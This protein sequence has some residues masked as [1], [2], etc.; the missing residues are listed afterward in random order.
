M[1][2]GKKIDRI[3][4]RPGVSVLSVLSHLNYRPWFALAE[5][6]DNSIQSF[7][8]YRDEIE[9]I[10]NESVIL[11]ITIEIDPSD[12]GR[13]TVR[14][15]AAGIHQT[16]FPRA[17]RPAQVPPDTTGLSEFG[18][19]MK[20][21]ACW[22]SPKWEVRTSSIGEHTEKHVTFDIAKIVRDDLE[23]LTVK[24]RKSK[25]ESHF[26]EVTLNKLHHLPVGRTL[27]KI[28][29]HLREIYRV[30][31]REGTLVLT[32]NGEE[33]NYQEPVVLVA[34]LFN[35]NNEPKGESL[36]WKKELEFDFGE[37]LIA[38][39]FAALRKKGSTTHA[40]FSL[41]R[42][43]RLIQGS[44]DEK[45]R[46]SYI[47]GAPNDYVYQR[48]FGELHL[49]GFEVSHT[50]DGFQWDENEQPFLEILREELENTP[51]TL[52]R[53]AR[54][55]RTRPNRRTLR[56]AAK[57]ATERTGNSIEKNLPP[58]VNQISKSSVNDPTKPELQTAE[59]AS[60][61]IIEFDF[62]DRRWRII[63]ELTDDPSVGEWLEVSDSVLR[64]QYSQKQSS[65]KTVE[66]IGLRMS[67][68]HPF[69]ERFVG[70][71]SEKIEPVLRV[72]AA[73]GLAE[74]LARESGVKFAGS[75]RNNVNKILTEA[76]ARIE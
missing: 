16:E 54:N 1:T 26:T 11:R 13:V 59:V 20:S 15:N 31:T 72:A 34:P 33:L 42:R 28:K 21:A 49:E 64:E 63:L 19:G 67:L 36:E 66:L 35:A 3:N 58:V 70:I 48:L 24:S 5:F 51:L 17:F 41:F 7:L 37:G 39:G 2:Q 74:K 68:V 61:R 22:F 76:L 9:S 45:Y 29:E 30:F 10:E 27:G 32:V 52:I 46:P 50:K 60:Q 18:M 56:T 57:R 62:S 53:Q 44:A 6:V 75:V 4:I 73:L 8:D 47:F 43:N 65:K 25:A 12:G 14:D 23:E 38:K 69:M 71:E 40:G 55:Y